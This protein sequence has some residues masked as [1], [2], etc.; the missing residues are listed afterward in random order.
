MV[1]HKGTQMEMHNAENI[2]VV[3]VHALGSALI[4]L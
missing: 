4:A 2:W 3:F 1:S